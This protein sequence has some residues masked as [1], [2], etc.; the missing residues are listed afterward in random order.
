[1]MPRSYQGEHKVRFGSEEKVVGSH[2]SEEDGSQT[3]KRKRKTS[4][5]KDFYQRGGRLT[6]QS[7]RKGTCMSWVLEA[8]LMWSSQD[9]LPRQPMCLISHAKQARER[10]FMYAIRGSSQPCRSGPTT[11][12][13]NCTRQL[14]LA[15]YPSEIAAD[16]SRFAVGK[17]SGRDRDLLR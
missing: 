4:A 14:D 5:L 7:S 6:L 12:L 8:Y 17:S 1:M 16:V 13:L 15:M 3:A 2:I 11:M 9:R 10:S